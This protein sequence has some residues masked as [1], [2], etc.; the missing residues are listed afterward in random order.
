MD[1]ASHHA[2][3][4]ATTDGNTHRVCFAHGHGYWVCNC[5][6]HCDFHRYRDFDSNCHIHQHTYANQY[7]I[8][9]R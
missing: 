6:S 5:N 9:T 4:F 7:A 2:P 8:A 1:R 3:Q